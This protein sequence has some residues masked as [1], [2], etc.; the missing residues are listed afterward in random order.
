MS[1]QEILEKLRSLMARTGPGRTEWAK[2]SEADAIAALGIDSLAMLDFLYDIQQEF[3]IELDPR[4]LV[5]VTTVGQMVS[6]I[7]E[8]KGA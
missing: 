1:R 8:R 7:G 2:V 5:S 6:F 3:G 4:D